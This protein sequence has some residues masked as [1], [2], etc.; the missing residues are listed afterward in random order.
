MHIIHLNDERYQAICAIIEKYA[1]GDKKC[2]ISH[3]PT[4]KG[5]PKVSREFV[6]KWNTILYN[7]G[8]GEFRNTIK[9]MLR[10]AG[11]GVEE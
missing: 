7:T 4:E 11:V 1:K 3:T 6:E 9:A 5:Q 10:E 8:M 2:R